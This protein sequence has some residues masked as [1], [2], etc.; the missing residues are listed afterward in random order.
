MSANASYAKWIEK[1]AEPRSI[2]LVEDDLHLVEL[3][4]RLI[5]G[6]NCELFPTS[7]GEMALRAI[8][9]KPFDFVFLDLGLPGISGVEVFK[10][11]KAVR[12]H[13]RIIVISGMLDRGNIDEINNVGFAA[14]IRKPADFNKV[15]IEDLFGTLG[16]PIKRPSE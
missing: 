3:M 1:L 14:F 12:P 8:A 15:F 5:K 4:E 2:L 6:Y 9:Q 11:I 16:I 7:N 13:Q 10:Q